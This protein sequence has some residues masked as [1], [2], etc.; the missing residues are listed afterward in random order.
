MKRMR[1]AF[2][3]SSLSVL[4]LAF[5]ITGVNGCNFD[6]GSENRL[7]TS[8]QKPILAPPEGVTKVEALYKFT[9]FTDKTDTQLAWQLTLLVDS[10]PPQPPPSPPASLT[11]EQLNNPFL[12]GRLNGQPVRPSE[13]CMTF[14]Y[15][16]IDR[17]E[18]TLLEKS[19]TLP[20]EKSKEESWE[21]THW[22]P[23][24]AAILTAKIEVQSEI[25]WRWSCQ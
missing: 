20:I 2:S 23:L 16:L 6:Q 8:P 24:Q 3:R 9:G 4:T 15:K 19:F 10:L 13:T 25:A 17:D 21:I 5:L 14:N 7:N 1:M 18:F 12:K 11:P 22:V